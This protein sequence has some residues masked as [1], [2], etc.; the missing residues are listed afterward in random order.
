MTKWG[1]FLLRCGV[2][3]SGE[4]LLTEE[5][6]ADMCS[7]HILREP[8]IGAY[9]GYGMLI[10]PL[11]D[12]YVYGHNGNIDPYNS[13]IFVDYKTGLGV[14][15]LMNSA[16]PNIRTELMEIVFSMAE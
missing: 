16:A 14:V 12:R 13:S 4:R 15:V 2:T 8:D 11:A 5:T 3:D 7:K 6:F 10:Y 1:R 9:Y